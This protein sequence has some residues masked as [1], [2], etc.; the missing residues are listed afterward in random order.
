LARPCIFLDRDGVINFSPPRGEYVRSWD[1][2]RLIPQI[3]D[4]I[5]LFRHLGYLV[6]V[7]TNQRGVSSGLF[8]ED[9]L[10]DIHNRMVEVLASQGACIDD[11]FYC[12]HALNTCDCRKPSPG[13]IRR[14]VEK[15]DIDVKRS[16]MIGDSPSDE[17]LAVN[18]G[19]MFVPVVEGRVL[20]R[21]PGQAGDG[22]QQQ[23]VSGLP[24]T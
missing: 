13:M 3:V 9:T 2:F 14:A 19:L 16:A 12:P 6:I 8:T 10:Q 1:E 20:L 7:V 18:C 17:E 4:W 15:W 21:L 23:P 5:R 22:Q 24:T 11:V